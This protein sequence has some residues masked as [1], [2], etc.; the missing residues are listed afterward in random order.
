VVRERLLDVIDPRPIGSG[1]LDD[2]EG[3]VGVWVT[4][5]IPE[6]L[7]GGCLD[8]VPHCERR[9]GVVTVDDGGAVEQRVDHREAP[10]GG[11]SSCEQFPRHPVP[12][13][14]ELGVPRFVLRPERLVVCDLADA[15]RPGD[16][17]CE[18]GCEGFEVRPSQRSAAG[19]VLG[20]LHGYEREPVGESVGGV[21]AGQFLPEFRGGDATDQP[22][23][24]PGGGRRFVFDGVPEVVPVPCLP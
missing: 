6:D 13:G 1:V 20:F 19:Q 17:L 18:F 4:D 9:P 15:L 23:V 22:D 12:L 5:R 8:V 11:C 10:D 24:R 2:G 21:G 16:C 7:D 14:G 3:F